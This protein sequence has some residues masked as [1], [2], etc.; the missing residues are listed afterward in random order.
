MLKKYITLVV[1]LF[2]SSIINAQNCDL[3]IEGEII[4]FHD[5]STLEGAII[6]NKKTGKEYRT[7][8]N[9]QFLIND[10]CP[11]KYQFVLSHPECDD[12]T[13]D[14]NLTE[15]QKVSWSM[16]HHLVELEAVEQEGTIAK[17]IESLPEEHLHQKDLDKYATSNIGD[18]LTQLTGVSALETGNSIVKP[19]IH[20]LHSSRVV[21][22]NNGVRQEDMEWG[23]E[24]SPNMDINAFNHIS[25]IKGAG[26]LRYGGDAIAGVVLTDYPDILRTK[27]FKGSLSLNGITNGRGGSGNINLQKGFGNGW[28]IN[29]QA[30]YLRNGD[31]SAPDYILSN[32]GVAQKAFRVEFGENSFK[33]KLKFSYSFFQKRMGIMLASHFGNMV[34][35]ANAIN[36]EEPATIRDFTYDISKPY[37]KIIH[38][39]AKA[40]WEKRI[41]NFGKLEFNYAFQ[42]NHRYEYDNR[43]GEVKETPSMDTELKTHS[44]EGVLSLDSFNDLKIQ[45]GFSGGYQDNYSSPDTQVKRLI[46]D[47]NKLNAGVFTALNY[48]KEAWNFNA[49]LRYDFSYMHTKKYYR[50]RLWDS[51]G[52]DKIFHENILDDYSNEWLVKFDLKY[53]NFS[54]AVGAVYNFDNQ[55]NISLSYS[56][57]NRAPNPSELFSEGLHHSASA[58]EIGDVLLSPETSHKINLG[59]KYNIELLEGLDLDFNLYHNR[60]NN[61]IYQ[62]PQ[63]LQNTIRGAFQ[64]MAYEQVNVAL[65]GFDFNSELKIN[66]NLNY[67]NKLAYLYANDLT[68][69]LPLIN[70]PPLQWDSE[71]EWTNRE[72]TWKPYVSLSSHFTAKQNRFPDYNFEVKDVFVNNKLTTIYPDISTP[73]NSYWLFDFNAGISTNWVG[74]SLDFN[75]FVKNLFNQSYRNYLNRYRYFADET[76]RQIQLQAIIKF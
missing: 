16:E 54:G 40:E 65:S 73:P 35:L 53:H 30:S 51:K 3:K 32:T 6:K 1:I 36:R 58:I 48:K 74:K 56:V 49:G 20:G 42:F 28:G 23:V 50:K 2:I 59:T 24:H 70:M 19:M 17:K 57:A 66:N 52:Y 18:A 11:G 46:P 61:F 10:L 76:G 25:V 33:N 15:N 31:F 37:Q 21:I 64:V 12:E 67:K 43:R 71:L 62:V 75:L 5:M 47:Y 34:D 38:H 27:S 9:G 44:V 39:L 41:Q 14:V 4:D 68:H 60:I 69:D 13:I 55:R 29:A 63:G 26:A 22:Y 72:N 7:D 8:K 45:G